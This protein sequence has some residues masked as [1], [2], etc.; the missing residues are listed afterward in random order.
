MIATITTTIMIMIVTTTTRTVTITMTANGPG[1]NDEKR[2]NETIFRRIWLPHCTLACAVC[3]PRTEGVYV[4][5][6]LRYDN[7]DLK[8][9]KPHLRNPSSSS[10]RSSSSRQP[11]KVGTRV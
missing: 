3:V 4:A 8:H 9:T 6:R 1:T 11:R 7:R 10:R 5:Q 2:G